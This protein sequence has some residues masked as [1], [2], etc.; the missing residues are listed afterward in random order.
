VSYPELTDRVAAE[1]TGRG[2]WLV[3]VGGPV[4]VGKSTVAAS[5]AGELEARGR[6]VAVVAT[7]SF[8]LSNAVLAE[9]DL[10]YR[11]GFPESFD[12]DAIARFLSSARAGSTTITIP[13]YSHEIYDILEGGTAEIPAFD[14]L[15]LEG[16]AALQAPAVDLLDVAIYV[17]AEEGDVRKWFVER[18]LQLTARASEDTSSFYR[19]FAGIGSDEVRALAEGTWDTINGVNLHEHIAPSRS[20]AT[21]VVEKADDHSMRVLEA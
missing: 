7:D 8:L 15:I 12:T 1:L 4:A 16:V 3:G 13:V 9:R 11:K 14:V 17:D 5:L 20:R 10:L 21:I 6:R 18:F 2:P 19:R